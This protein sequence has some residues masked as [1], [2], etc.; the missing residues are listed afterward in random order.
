MKSELG[1]LY[2]SASTTVG[3][4]GNMLTANELVFE[5]SFCATPHVFA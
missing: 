1:I 5:D 4:S 2:L 3:S